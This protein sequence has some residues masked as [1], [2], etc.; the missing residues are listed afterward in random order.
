MPEL[1]CPRR[2]V[3]D[4]RRTL[5]RVC[6]FQPAYHYW[7]AAQQSAD[8]HS[9]GAGAAL[10]FYSDQ[11]A[12]WILNLGLVLPDP[13]PR[14]G[15][16]LPLHLQLERVNGQS[17]HLMAFSVNLNIRDNLAARIPVAAYP[18]AVEQFFV[19]HC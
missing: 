12:V 18:T 19:A 5:A 2:H 3:R 15:K 1:S 4:G 13:S 9:N 14:S 6:H 10:K 17:L 11:Q 16:F 8:S 7:T